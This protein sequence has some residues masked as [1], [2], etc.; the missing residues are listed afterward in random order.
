MSRAASRSRLREQAELRD[1]VDRIARVNPTGRGCPASEE[2][3]RYAEKARLQSLLIERYPEDVRAQAHEAMPGVVSLSVPRLR[4][5]AAHAIVEAL[6]DRARALVEAQI[7]AAA[8]EP[9]PA[10]GRA[11]Q[12]APQVRGDPRLARAAKL[13]AE[14]DFECAEAELASL[15]ADAAAASTDRARALVLLLELYVDHL[16]NDG[17]ALALEPP[18]RALG[19]LPDEAHELLGVAAA[20]AGDAAAALQHLRRCGGER[21]AVSL[22]SLARACAA[23]RAWDAATCAWERLRALAMTAEP[24]AAAKVAAIRDDLRRHLAPLAERAEEGELASDEDLVR[25][26]RELAPGH[27]WLRERRE[28]AQKSRSDASARAL[29][30]RG[31]ACARDGDLAGAEHALALLGRCRIE[32]PADAAR[33]EELASWAED[34][35]AEALAAR[36]VS[37]AA[38]GDVEAACRVYGASPARARES[39]RAACET[40]LFTVLDALGA[41]FPERACARPLVRAAAAWVAAQGQ[42]DP[43]ERWSLVEPHA[44]LLEGVPELTAEVRRL[45]ACSAAPRRVEAAAQAQAR[46][47][48]TPREVCA[49]GLRFLDTAGQAPG[50][51]ETIDVGLFAVRAGAISHVVTLDALGERGAW[52]I[53]LWPAGSHAPARRISIMGPASFQPRC[54]WTTSRRIGVAD[55]SGRFW[56]LTLEPELAVSRVDLAVSGEC[57]QIIPVDSSALA[58]AAEGEGPTPSVW[59]LLDARTGA[60]LREI[61]GPRIHRTRTA[62]GTVFHRVSG[63]RVERLGPA[64]DVVRHFELPWGMSPSAIVESP[65]GELPVL[66]SEPVEQRAAMLWWQPEGRFFRAFELFDATEHG[67]AV[68]AVTLAG[69]GLCVV[70]RRRDG[71]SFLHLVRARKSAL[72]PVHHAIEAP[73]HLGLVLD[74]SGRRGWTV[75]RAR[76]RGVEIQPLRLQDDTA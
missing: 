16:A 42:L 65:L 49:D 69:R 52:Q 19:P 48:A 32:D 10:P 76:G 17:A 37:L 53:G 12:P 41:A 73:G 70:T 33:I 55:T 47:P 38:A 18:L 25:F 13:V 9:A 75:R 67:D 58:I 68:D 27:T 30:D 21:V 39:A 59:R 45:R 72:R 8:A 43:G 63:P 5:S 3:A 34:R 29:L 61:S 14:Y 15:A 57:G 4:A 66:L 46:A 6:S 22:A 28:L 40:P 56:V 62:H 7:D 1:L 51:A 20:R 50:P 44:V 64:G 35:R 11:P 71:A 36:A 2:K 24:P 26:V 23:A 74:S 60:L 54:L 31:Q